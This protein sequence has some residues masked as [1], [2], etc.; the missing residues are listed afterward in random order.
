MQAI[1]ATDLRILKVLQEDG[2]LTGTQVA[3]R[4]GISQSP[5]SRRIQALTDAGIIMGRT[6]ELDRRKLGFDLLVETRIKLQSHDPK[7]LEAFKIAVASIA[8]IQSAMMMLG[9]FDFRFQVVVRDIGHYQALLQNRLTS[10]PGVKE[11]QS[12]VVLETIKSTSAL[13]L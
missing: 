13:P 4:A 12:S 11:M 5:C 2:G 3:E 6:I 1:D 9:E 7:L 8:E 10:L